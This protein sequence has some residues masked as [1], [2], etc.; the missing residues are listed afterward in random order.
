M[1]EKLGSEILIDMQ[2]GTG[3]M[4][5]AVD[6]DVRAKRGERLRYGLN[7]GGLHFFDGTDEV[8]I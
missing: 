1:V 8:A 6:P 7:P 4:V 3:T 5:A 2:V